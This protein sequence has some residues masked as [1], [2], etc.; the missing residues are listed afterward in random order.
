MIKAI[1]SL[2]FATL[3]LAGWGARAGTQVTVDYNGNDEATPA[4]SFKTVP[5]PAGNSVAMSATFTI[6][7]GAIDPASG[8]P[9]KLHDAKLPQEADQPGE[10]FFFS[11]GSDGGRIRVDLGTNTEIHQVNTY[12][13][14]PGSRGP[15]VYKLYASDG[16]AP[17]FN[18]GPAKGTAPDQCGW[19]FLASVNTQ[20]ASGDGGGQYGV[21]IANPGGSLGTYRYLLF[22]VAAAER[23]DDFG[24][25][26]YSE[27]DVIGTNRPLPIRPPSEQVYTFKTTDGKCTI[28]VIY[29]DAPKLKD[30][31]EQTL[32]P[33]LADYY[34]KI[35]A[36]LPSPGYTA[37]TRFSITLK[38]M[39]GVAY[40]AGRQVVA[41]SDWLE[42]E[43][44][45][46]AVGSLVHEC[47]HVVQ[48]F[49]GNNP[50][51]LVEGSADYIRWFKY[52]PQSH[53]ADMVWARRE[54]H[55]KPQYDGSYRITANFLNWVSEKYDPKIVSEM[56][57][58]MREDRY[59]ESLWSQY[60]GKSA[61]EL[62]AEWAKEVEAQLAAPTPASS[63]TGGTIE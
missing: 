61:P 36:M 8:G 10:N 12:S 20:P 21:S 3:I 25:T 43:I 34:P 1:Q 56:N 44:G 32:A 24:N 54:P 47:V 52:E 17:N 38:P 28:R 37:P 4:F 31:A 42:N 60:T 13:W 19:T 7:D 58:A 45:R 53:G 18:V 26:F 63:R 22:E 2:T 11:P 41:N 51:W 27:I 50:G 35:V 15:Q 6:V 59:D 5:S 16:T 23:E 40:T 57:A 55:Y 39:D 14:H 62:G 46:Q 30:W 49:H 33:V 9:D 29:T 48:Q